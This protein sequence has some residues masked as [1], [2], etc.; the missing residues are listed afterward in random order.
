M[1]YPTQDIVGTIVGV[2]PGFTRNNKQKFDVQVQHA[3]GQE[4]FTTFRP[5]AA[6]KAQSLVG[7]QNVTVR[8]SINGTYK[9]FEDAFPGGSAPVAQQAFTATAPAPG[10]PAPAQAPGQFT[11]AAGFQDQEKIAKER[12]IIRGNAINAAAAALGPLIGTGIFVDEDGVLQHETVE[13]CIV[14]LA[15]NLA[16]YIDQGPGVKEGVESNPAPLAPG[17]SPAEV[18]A[19]AAQAGPVSVGAPVPTTEAP[20]EEKPY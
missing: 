5:D 3:G 2:A 11:P 10:F 1:S 4:A 8:I 20:A 17:V 16:L 13:N 7:Q 18:A 14:G 12:R 19:Y 6:S 15:R 9:N